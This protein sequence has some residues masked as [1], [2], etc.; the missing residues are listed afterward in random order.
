MSTS[1]SSCSMEPKP[2]APWNRFTV[3]DASHPSFGTACTPKFDMHGFRVVAMTP[4]PEQPEMQ[5]R[6]PG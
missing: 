5:K 3:P 6:S 2:S 1:S 4:L